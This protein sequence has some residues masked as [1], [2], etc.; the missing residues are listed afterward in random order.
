[1]L[2][3]I[4]GICQ[5][6]AAEVS[7]LVN[8]G[9]LLGRCPE[10][11]EWPMHMRKIA[12]VVYVVSNPNQTGVKIGMTTKPIEQRLRSLNSTGVPGQFETIAVFPSDRPKVDE[13]RVHDK[14]QRYNIAKEH[15]DLDP[16]EATLKAY[17]ALGRREP[18]FFRDDLK[19]TFE[20]RLEQER[21]KMKLR[22]KGRSAS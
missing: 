13:K 2:L 15:F 6:C 12:G 22:L 3:E 9:E 10:C 17:R 18:I 4:S 11:R 21:I 1:M 16:I 7:V 5:N 20:L 19:E 8:N 14:V